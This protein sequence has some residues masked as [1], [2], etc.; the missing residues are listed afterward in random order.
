MTRTDLDPTYVHA[1]W[2]AAALS[3]VALL[4]ALSAWLDG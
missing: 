4:A 2:Q 3:Q 1:A